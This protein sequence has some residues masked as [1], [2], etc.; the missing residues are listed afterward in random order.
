MAAESLISDPQPAGC[1]P[2]S[3]N[4]RAACRAV[5]MG[6]G[7]GQGHSRHWGAAVG[8]V[9]QP[10]EGQLLQKIHPHFQ[11]LSCCV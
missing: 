7:Q 3:H 8:V 5:E 4:P 6:T 9:A 1:L 10:A 11:H 2:C